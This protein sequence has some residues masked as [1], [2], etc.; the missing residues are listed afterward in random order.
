LKRIYLAKITDRKKQ[1]LYQDIEFIDFVGNMDDDRFN[2]NR[3]NYLGEW[4]KPTL[5]KELTN[6]SN[7]VLLSDGEAHPL[8]CCEA[9][10]CGL[11]LV[12]SE[13]SSANL[14]VNLPFIDVIPNE[15][16]KDINYVS[17]LI[18]SNQKKSLSLRREIRNYGIENFSWSRIIKRYLDTVGSSIR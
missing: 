9:L 14:D 17:E 15:K 3:S 8:V 16:I 2:R 6:Y 5:Y 10:M 4:D 7:L 18:L 1:Y 11:G 13:C 12:I